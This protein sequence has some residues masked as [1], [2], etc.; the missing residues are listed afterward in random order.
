MRNVFFGVDDFCGVSPLIAV[1]PG[2]R[3][4]EC[5]AGDGAAKLGEG[6]L[7]AF[8]WD[9]VFREPCGFRSTGSDRL[10]Q[11]TMHVASSNHVA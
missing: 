5:A 1:L 3:Q 10:R 7:N 8:F 6:F 2:E 4:C 11:R 9:S